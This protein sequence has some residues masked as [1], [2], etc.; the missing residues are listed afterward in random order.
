MSELISEE[1][2][3]AAKD[4]SIPDSD[5]DDS[6]ADSLDSEGFDKNDPYAAQAK[7]I[8]KRNKIVQ[9]FHQRPIMRASKTIIDNKEN[10]TYFEKHTLKY[11]VCFGLLGYL[12]YTN[13][14]M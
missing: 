11:I 1:Q 10:M 4:S 8:N 6:D 7:S 3:H 12:I 9:D 13:L 5:K 14:S 2:K